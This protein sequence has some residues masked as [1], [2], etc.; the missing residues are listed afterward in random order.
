MTGLRSGLV[1]EYDIAE[2]NEL[3]S[4]SP[5]IHHLAGHVQGMNDTREP[6]QDCQTDVDQEIS[7]ASSLQENT[8]WRQDDR[9]DDLADIP[10]VPTALAYPRHYALVIQIIGIASYPKTAP[11]RQGPGMRATG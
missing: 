5:E 11:A 2:R 7:T 9:K 1:F 10:M 8:Q 3:A 4:E 6:T